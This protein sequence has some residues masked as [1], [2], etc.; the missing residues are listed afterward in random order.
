MSES[1]LLKGR[2]IL[3]VDDRYEITRLYIER[4]KAAGAETLYVSR[5]EDAFT[6][7]DGHAVDVAVLDL[8][9]PAPLP[10]YGPKYESAIRFFVDNVS[11]EI[12]Q[13]NLGQML[14]YH[15]SKTRA[16]KPP[17]LYLSAVAAFYIP[18]PEA[19]IAEPVCLDRNEKTPAELVEAI[20]AVL[21]Q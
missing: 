10:P 17:Y 6:A 9:M 13:N 20:I 2:V 5:L 15:I 16:G 1:G 8:H 21:G 14:G 12:R 18:I 19:G 3:F 7:L 4:C 11:S